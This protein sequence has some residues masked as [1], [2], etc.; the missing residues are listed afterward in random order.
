MTS[1]LPATLDAISEGLQIIGFDWRYLYL[2]EAACRHARRRR[3]QLLGQVMTEAYPG[4]GGT[5]LYKTLQAC[6]HDRTARQLDDEFTYPDGGTA[7][8]QL[9]IEPCPQGLCILS[10]DVGEQRELQS[11]RQQAQKMEAIGKLAGGVAHDFNNLLTAIQGFTVFALET[12]EATHPAVADL[13]EALSAIDRAGTLTRQ[14][15]AFA[16]NQPVTPRLIDVNATVASVDKLLRRLLGEDIE[17]QTR[18]GQP[19]ATGEAW[20]ALIDPGAFEQLLVNLAV[21]ARDAMPSGGRLTVETAAVVV[22]EPQA[23]ARGHVIEPGAYV[24]LAV[25]DEGIGMERAVLE[26][27]FDPFFTTKPAGKGTGLGLSICYG[28]VRQAGGYIWASSEPGHGS[29][30][31]IYLPRASGTPA[32]PR[33]PAARPDAGGGDETILLVEADA[34]VRLVSERAL[35]E[36]GYWVMS[37]ANPREALAIVDGHRS[38]IHLL[39]TDVTMPGGRGHDLALRLATRHPKMRVLYL[40]GHAAPAMIRRGTLPPTAEVLPKPFSPG[41]LVRRVRDVLDAAS[42]PAEGGVDDVTPARQRPLVMVVDDDELFRR[43][44][45]RQLRELGCQVVVSPDSDHAVELARQT[46]PAVILLD[47]N[48]PGLDGHALLRRIPAADVQASIVVISG[49]RGVDDIID[50][51]RAGAVDYLRKPSSL[52]DLSSAL[53]RALGIFRTIT[54]RLA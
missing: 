47:L 17:I 16:R 6:M 7:L 50:A 20:Q 36:A 15:L 12:M 29:A 45:E 39:V 33:L 41:A 32:E 4:I 30:F 9:R 35:H 51:L 54:G 14:L 34:Q 53:G 5:E 26:Q 22:D 46:Q 48:M 19:D 21:N 27:I 43:S 37:A 42:A 40:S 31:R 1:L 11:Q 28:I 10:V 3:E 2:N 13:R 23:L 49:R 38:A 24:T 8:L 25:S 44:L 18:L 52:E